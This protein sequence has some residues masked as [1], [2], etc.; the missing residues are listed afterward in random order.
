LRFEQ[1]I[2]KAQITNL[3]SPKPLHRFEVK[4]LEHKQV[5]Y[6]D[7]HASLLPLPIV[8]DM[9]TFLCTRAASSLA[10]LRAFDPF[11][12]RLNTR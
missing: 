9:A 11:C 8:A 2:S 1:E 4:R 6:C 7:Q 3:S 12:F 10:R 5:E